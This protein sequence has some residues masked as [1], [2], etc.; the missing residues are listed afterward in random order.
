MSNYLEK[1][2]EQREKRIAANKAAAAGDKQAVLLIENLA[3][4]VKTWWTKDPIEIRFRVL[5]FMVSKKDNIGDDQVG[6]FVNVRKYSVHFIGE[7]GYI[8]PSTYGLPCP[9]C[10]KFK[11]FSEA[12]RKDINSPAQRFKPKHYALFNALFELA[13]E[14]GKTKLVMRVINAGYFST[15]QKILNAVKNTSATNAANDRKINLFDDPEE[16]YWIEA[17]CAKD[18][19][20]GGGSEKSKFMQFTSVGLRW[21]EAVKPLSD[22]VF[23]MI[24]DL[25]L[26]IPE[27]PSHATLLRLIGESTPAPAPEEAEA[28][29]ETETDLTADDDLSSED[30]IPMGEVADANTKA[31]KAKKASPKKPEAEPEPEPVA[32]DDATIDGEEDA[33]GFDADDFDL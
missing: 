2:R 15:W 5:P 33:D 16:G 18:S 9:I 21:R 11:S 30:A 29:E 3:K 24:T 23:D 22:K 12:E 31:H 26:L 4:G 28:E 7:K 19:I 13:D 25:D 1:L 27:P 17:Q 20:S 14:S 8:C 32:E 6:D 10:D